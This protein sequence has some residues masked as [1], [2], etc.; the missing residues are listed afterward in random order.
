MELSREV[1]V[2]ANG[3]PR[4][5]GAAQ[6]DGPQIAKW[7]TGCE[8]S[9]YIFA[10]AVLDMH[11]LQPELHPKVC[12]WLTRVPP[13]R[14][15]L[16]MPRGHCKSTLIAEAMPLHM[17]IQP[18]E[19]NIYIA[20]ELGSETRILIAGESESRAKDHLRII[21]DQLTGNELLRAFWPHIVWDNPRRDAPLWNSQDIIIRREREAPD[22][23]ARAVGVGTAVTG[24]HP[25]VLIQDDLTTEEAANSPTIM[26]GAIQWHQNSHAL[27]SDQERGLV[28]VTGTRWS[29]ADLPDHI[30][31]NQPEYEVNVDWRGMIEDGQVIYPKKFG[32]EGAAAKLR[33]LHGT[34]FPL[35]Y[36]NRVEDS[37]LVDFDVADLREFEIAGS[38]L[39]FQ[40]DPRDADLAR[41]IARPVLPRVVPDLSKVPPVA[42]AAINYPATP[43]ELVGGPRPA[44]RGSALA[45]ARKRVDAIFAEQDRDRAGV[46]R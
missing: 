36:F 2:D 11:W 43:G 20:G 30:M 23:S 8:R 16:M 10:R 37:G 14:K 17:F 5:A 32:Y 19:A 42:R 38:M 28:Y 21:T 45:L 25:G 33:A 13:Y 4:Q 7:R 44:D 27:L 9:L 39:R 34:M 22:P 26:Q 1:V 31:T 3:Q 24:M 40:G 41:E 6:A 12:A 29:V 18:R 46:R 15:L 35:L